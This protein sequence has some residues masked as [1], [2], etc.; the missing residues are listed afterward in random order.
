MIETFGA[1]TTLHRN[2]T[3]A[4]TPWRGAAELPKLMFASALI[5]PIAFGQIA[6]TTTQ[7]AKKI[8][9]SVV[10]IQ[11]KT[12]SGDVLGSGF[13]VS[14]D[15]KIVTNLH[16]IRGLNTASI[17]LTNGEVFDSI[18]VLAADERRDLAIVKIAG[19]DLPVLELGNFNSLTVGEPVVI[20]GSPRGL[21][22]TVTAGILSS[23]RDSGDGFKVLQTDAAVNPGNSGGPLVNSK[24]QAIGVVSFKLRSSEGLNFAI[25]INYVSGLLNNL[26][27]PISL[28]QMRRTLG[29]RPS[30]EQSSGPSLEETLGWLREKIPLAAIHYVFTD[31]PFTMGPTK[32]VRI[33]AVPIHFDSCTVIFDFTEVVV[34][35]RYSERSI[36]TTTRYTIPLGSVDGGDVTNL[37]IGLS[38]TNKAS[39]FEGW[40]VGLDSK[41]KLILSEEHEDLRNTTKN[42]SAGVALMVFNDE[43]I[44]KRVLEAFLHA[45][46]LCRKKKEPF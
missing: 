7:I 22:G 21:E 33:R 16:V 10:V 31:L 20:V 3:P 30:V 38:I 37:H 5:L 34:W 42:E 32:D 45:S 36:T 8:S 17:Q 46:D 39:T 12:D 41:S 40:T 9:P 13:I 27:E 15:G 43:L 29:T 18:L 19:F 2:H 6:L 14:R 23:I 26:H 35:E 4:T 25:P 1:A 11:G 28:E 44:A 24:G